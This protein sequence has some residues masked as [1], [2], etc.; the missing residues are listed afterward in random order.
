[1]ASIFDSN[2]DALVNPVNTVGVSGAGLALD[3][4]ARYRENY[5]AYVKECSSGRLKVGSVFAFY[6]KGK[7]IINFPT[8]DHWRD[9]SK[10]NY[11]KSGLTAMV[12]VLKEKGIKSVAVPH[13]GCGLGGLNW[14]DVEPLVS[15]ALAE[16]EV[17][18]V[19]PR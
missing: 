4:K 14:A 8:K 7:W 9:S 5:E 12:E 6:E 1:M 19:A 17:E 13:I 2:C 18:I 10:L 3:F 15:S 11:I 16:F